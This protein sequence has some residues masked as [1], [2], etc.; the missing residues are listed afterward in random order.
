[1]NNLTDAW[2]SLNKDKQCFTWRTKSFKIQ[3]RLDFF[4]VSQELI[5]STKKCEIVYAPEFDHS[6]VSFVLQSNHL[7]QKGNLVSGNL[8]Q[9]YLRMKHT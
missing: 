1:M 9:P 2:R 7:N 8:I 6:A 5:Q 4:L 3:C